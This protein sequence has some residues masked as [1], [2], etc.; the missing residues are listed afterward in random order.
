MSAQ[1]LIAAASAILAGGSAWTQH[2]NAK[3]AAGKFVPT[4][5]ADAV[6]WDVF[7][8][9]QKAHYDSG[10]PSFADYNDAYRLMKSRIPATARSRDMEAFN[11]EVSTFAEVAVLFA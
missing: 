7:G 1:T 11:D 8:A 6:A 4:M 3:N 9:L 2:A 10:N 5:S